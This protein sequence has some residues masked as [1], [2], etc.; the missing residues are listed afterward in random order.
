MKELVVLFAMYVFAVAAAA[1]QSLGEIARANRAQKSPIPATMQWNDDTMPR[2]SAPA[3]SLKPEPRK[4]DEEAP[5]TREADAWEAAQINSDDARKLKLDEL[6]KQIE[7]QEK[8]I[9]LLQRELNVARGETELRVAAYYG[10]AGVMLR[11]P[12]QYFEVARAQ[13]EEI[14]I[15]QQELEAARQTLADLQ[16]LAQ[17]ARAGLIFASVATR[18]VEDNARLRR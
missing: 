13:L 4:T 8:E 16:D 5:A 6:N 9:S 7:L 3:T 11:D 17:R 12:A 10:D 14:S 2:S 18:S 1:Q 15:R